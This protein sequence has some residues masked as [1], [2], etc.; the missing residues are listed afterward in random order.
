MKQP[1]PHAT[2]TGAHTPATEASAPSSWCSA[3]RE[4]PVQPEKAHATQRPSKVK[5]IKKKKE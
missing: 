5:N 1:I 2:T 3:T 4:K